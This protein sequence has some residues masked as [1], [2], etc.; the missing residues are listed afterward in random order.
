MNQRE[1]IL[2]INENHSN[3]H[4]PGCLQRER[5][6]KNAIFISTANSIQHEVM[7]TEICY[8]LKSQGHEY[9]TEAVRN[10][11]EENGKERRVDIVDLE[12]SDEIEIVFRHESDKEIKE[13]RA[14]GV[15][16]VLVDPIICE[17]CGLAY[18][19]R[20]SKNICQLCK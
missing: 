9:I 18:P 19:K 7:K 4:V 20:N 6:K 8:D 2:K 12:T 11:K 10:E 3:Y 14:K 15:I 16:V 17:K 5:L 1:K 13:Y